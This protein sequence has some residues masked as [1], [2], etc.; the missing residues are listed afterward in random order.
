MSEFF[1]NDRRRSQAYLKC[2]APSNNHQ[3]PALKRCG[4]KVGEIWAENSGKNWNA[5]EVQLD[6]LSKLT[7]AISLRLKNYGQTGSRRIRHLLK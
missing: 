4:E 5:F 6:I 1:I 2:S 7:A 3:K